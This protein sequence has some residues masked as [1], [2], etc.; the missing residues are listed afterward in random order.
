MNRKVIR[1]SFLITL[2]AALISCAKNEDKDS[3]REKFDF[4]N[5]PKVS[6]V[7]GGGFTNELLFP[8]TGKSR[9]VYDE[10][11]MI[12][13]GSTILAI[14]YDDDKS[15]TGNYLEIYFEEPVG[16]MSED[17]VVSFD[18]AY[19]SATAVFEYQEFP[20]YD[21]TDRDKDVL[22]SFYNKYHV[23]AFI[24]GKAEFQIDEKGRYLSGVLNVALIMD[25][26]DYFL[27][28]FD[29]LDIIDYTET[30]YPAGYNIWPN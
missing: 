6:L 25:E 8:S 5:N 30:Y 11:G 10:K 27:L 22:V 3:V 4:E 17:G 29:R 13:E 21:C 20:P 19:V 9:I 1:I 16:T 28:Q 12:S 7:K 2:F 15:A 26:N 18:D 24:S 14:K 23:K